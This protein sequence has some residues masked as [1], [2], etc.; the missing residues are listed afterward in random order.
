[1][2]ATTSL[3]PDQARAGDR[4]DALDLDPI[5]CKLMHPEPGQTT[6]TLAEADQLI[7]AY[8]GF[9]K[10]CAWYPDQSI[11][12]SKAIDEVWHAHIL[13]TAK[14]AADSR[15]VF[16]HFLHHFPYFGLRGPADEATWHAA[17][18]RTRHLFRLHFG[19]GTE[20]PGSGCGGGSDCNAQSACYHPP[21]HSRA[22]AECGGQMCDPA[23]QDRE[24]PRPDRTPAPL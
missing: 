1:M 14:Y 9:L 5:A 20:T 24:R 12:P 2:T 11:V 7:T 3:T 19:T 8:R 15:A 10:L 13:D 22:A 18:D 16:G 6:M 23:P 4:V 21:G 17:R